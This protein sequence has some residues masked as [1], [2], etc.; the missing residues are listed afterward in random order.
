M[1]QAKSQVEHLQGSNVILQNL[2][3]VAFR[4][5][6]DLRDV[7]ERI[8]PELE[9]CIDDTMPERVNLTEYNVSLHEVLTNSSNFSSQAL[10]AEMHLLRVYDEQ[11]GQYRRELEACRLCAPPTLVFAP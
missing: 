10:R 5:M 6:H 11:L 9:G 7:V 1:N 4:Q 2:V 8:T 3:I